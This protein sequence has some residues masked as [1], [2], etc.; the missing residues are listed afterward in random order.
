MRSLS[1]L[2]LL[3]AACAHA[4]PPPPPRVQMLHKCAVACDPA[5]AVGA[6]LTVNQSNEFWECLCK[7]AVA[8]K[9]PGT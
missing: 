8:A 4:P 2:L 1:A 6:S 3:L 5:E 7:E 9:S